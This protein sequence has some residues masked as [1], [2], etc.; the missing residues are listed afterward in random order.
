MRVPQHMARSGYS[1]VV[2]ADYRCHTVDGVTN[3]PAP[4]FKVWMQ[5]VLDAARIPTTD[6][7]DRGW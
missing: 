5:A 3:A 4:S 1:R 7:I 6:Q 2:P